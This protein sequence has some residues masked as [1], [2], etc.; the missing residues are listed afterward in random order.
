MRRLIS[1]LVAGSLITFLLI[2]IIALGVQSYLLLSSEFRVQSS[3]FGVNSE[4]GTPTI[5]MN[6]DL[7]ADLAE[8]EAIGQARHAIYTEQQATLQ[9]TIQERSTTYQ[10]QIAEAQRQLTL[11]QAATEQYQQDIHTLDEQISQLEQALAERE[12]DY[13]TQVEQA[14]QPFQDHHNQ[15]LAQREAARQALSAARTQL[16]R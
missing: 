15:L 8:L 9:A 2:M 4:L 5:A 1:L 6:Q 14:I 12:A 3:Q 11:Y 16:G 13:Q 7:A 10:S